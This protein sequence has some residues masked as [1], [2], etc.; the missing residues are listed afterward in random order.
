MPLEW[1]ARRIASSAAVSRPR[2]ALIRF[3]AAIDDGLG[4]LPFTAFAPFGRIGVFRAAMEA[5]VLG[6]LPMKLDLSQR[7]NVASTLSFAFCS[8]S[9]LHCQPVHLAIFHIA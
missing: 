6:L 1:M 8:L 3:C 9:P 2:V 4:R 5:R 7:F